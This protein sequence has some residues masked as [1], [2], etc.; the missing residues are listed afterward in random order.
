MT[1]IYEG[2]EITEDECEGHIQ[3]LESIKLTK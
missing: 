1:F 3:L 2:Q